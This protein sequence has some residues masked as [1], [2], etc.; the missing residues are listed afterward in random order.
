MIESLIFLHKWS[1]Y[2]LLVI[3]IKIEWN[4]FISFFH[5]LLG[6]FTAIVASM[7]EILPVSNAYNL[8]N[9]IG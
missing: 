6:D 2:V 4:V 7:K 5:I 8:F 1:F 3:Y 9:I